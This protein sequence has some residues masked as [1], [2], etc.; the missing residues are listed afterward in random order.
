MTL[1]VILFSTPQ[2][3]LLISIGQAEPSWA[4]LLSTRISRFEQFIF[5]VLRKDFSALFSFAYIIGNRCFVPCR[6]ICSWC[7]SSLTPSPQELAPTTTSQEVTSVDLTTAQ[8]ASTADS[9][10]ISSAVYAR[11][12]PS[13]D[14][15]MSMA[16]PSDGEV[17]I[18]ITGD[19]LCSFRF[20][21]GGGDPPAYAFPDGD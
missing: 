10:A 9:T 19:A 3:L 17:V 18:F 15:A 12:P 5:V 8:P 1:P 13:Y 16:R 14:E 4:I 2:I 21:K 7:C 11:S 20:T 6:C